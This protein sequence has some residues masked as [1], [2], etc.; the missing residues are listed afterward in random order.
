MSD[1][2]KILSAAGVADLVDQITELREKLQSATERLPCGHWKG[3][4]VEGNPADVIKTDEGTP[5][6][7][8]FGGEG[9][10]HTCAELLQ[11]AAAAMAQQREAMTQFINCP[12]HPDN[13]SLQCTGCSE[14]ARYREMFRNAP[15]AHIAQEWLEQHDLEIRISAERNVRSAVELA[16]TGEPQFALGWL[17]VAMAH[18]LAVA[19]L[20]EAKWWTQ[21]TGFHNLADGTEQAKRITKLE[22]E[23]TARQGEVK[24]H[25]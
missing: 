4:W 22:A 16:L 18:Q 2:P 7:R 12:L 13:S 5:S 6:E 19:R 23:A 21:R 10:C 17:A 14:T 11:R 1:Y 9:Y 8:W 15:L 24:S 25:A 3:D 20:D